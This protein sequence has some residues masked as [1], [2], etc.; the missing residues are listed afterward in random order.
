MAMKVVVTGAAGFLGQHV[1]AQLLERGHAVRAIIRPLTPAP[2]WNGNVALI[3]ADLETP[4]ALAGVLEGSDAVLHLA[5]AAAGKNDDEQFAA[6]ATATEHLAGA[7]TRARVTK[8]VLVSSLA[9]YNWARARGVL[10]EEAP[11]I[12][13]AAG[14]GGYVRAKLF[15]EC[16]FAT[17]AREQGWALTVLRPGFV[18]GPERAEVA[19][20]G[21]YFGPVQVMF[22]PVSTLPLTHVINCAHAVVAAAEAENVV[23]AFNVVDDDE[24]SV[25]RYAREHAVRSRRTAIP[26]PVPYTVGLLIARLASR[27]SR[28]L[29]GDDSKLPTILNPSRFEW[30]FKPLRFSNHKLKRTLG[31]RPRL[32]FDECLAVTYAPRSSNTASV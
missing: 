2:H 1:V 25:W 22:G 30:Q 16:A 11:L 21:R 27:T 19:G 10:D 28:I 31:W 9:V 15:Q 14:L 5:L 26:L 20:M 17:A 3:R 4:N 12:T 24:V 23:G 13:D 18:W 8:V 6:T 29:T 7:I 32:R